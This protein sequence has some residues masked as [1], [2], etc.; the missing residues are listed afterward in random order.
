V[1]GCMLRAV[2]V[3]LNFTGAVY[4]VGRLSSGPLGTST[5]ARGTRICGAGQG[6]GHSGGG[7]AVW[8]RLGLVFAPEGY[9]RV[10][11]G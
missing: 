2:P 9:E 8:G 10:A 3:G 6:E 5:G 11:R 7:R 1:I 4:A